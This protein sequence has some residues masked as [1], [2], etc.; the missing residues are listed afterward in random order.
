MKNTLTAILFLKLLMTAAA[1][2]AKDHAY[3][4]WNIDIDA[5]LSLEFNNNVYFEENDTSSDVVWHIIPSVSFE[6]EQLDNVLFSADLELN[7]HLY[8]KNSDANITETLVHVEARPVR[9]GGYFLCSDRYERLQSYSA[10]DGL[11]EMGIN[12]F[13][14][15]GGYGGD[16]LDVS[17]KAS[18]SNGRFSPGE[19]AL[20]NYNRSSVESEVSYRI[21]ALYWLAGLRFGRLDYS[22]DLFNDGRFWGMWGGVGKEITPKTSLEFKTEYFSQ[23][24][25]GGDSFGGLLF[26]FEGK[27]MYASEKGSVHL[28]IEREIVPSTV[29]GADYAAVTSV[30]VISKNEFAFNLTGEFELGIEFDSI[31]GRDDKVF[32]LSARGG[33]MPKKGLR[34]NF[35]IESASRSSSIEEFSFRQFL[36]TAGVAW[37]Y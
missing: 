36:L 27:H 10:S 12:T 37:V 1:S 22:D 5:A 34:I 11:V 20:L 4:P 13:D 32:N 26:T 18:F 24:H 2:M 16:H 14:I 19:F 21:N 23:S 3:G 17:G 28:L 9:Y 25:S 30:T 29:V 15:G 8:S 6:Y 31:G 7:T 33:Y 35:G